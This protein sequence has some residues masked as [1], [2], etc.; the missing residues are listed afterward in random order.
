M[1]CWFTKIPGVESRECDG[2]LRR[3]HLIR[4]QVIDKEAPLA[5]PWDERVW[6]WGCG[7]P[8]GVGGHHGKLDYSRTLRIPR[9]LLPPEVED[10]AEEHEIQWWLDR[11]YGE[12]EA[13]RDHQ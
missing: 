4:K 1:P 5:D 2:K 13:A 11:E 9:E 3:C 6:V 7:G 8:T 10:F 12:R